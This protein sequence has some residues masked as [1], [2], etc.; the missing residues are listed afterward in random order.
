M[1]VAVCSQGATTWLDLHILKNYA[2]RYEVRLN[3]FTEVT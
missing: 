2:V 1:I 3:R